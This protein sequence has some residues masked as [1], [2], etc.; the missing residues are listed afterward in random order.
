MRFPTARS[1]DPA[2]EPGSGPRIYQKSQGCSSGQD[3]AEP[4]HEARQHQGRSKQGDLAEW[5]AG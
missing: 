2:E 4:S 1:P 5:V 3:Y